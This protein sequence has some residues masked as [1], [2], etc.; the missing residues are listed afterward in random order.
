MY[1]ELAW[2]LLHRGVG[3][4][5]GLKWGL[6][7]RSWRV[8][9]RPIAEAIGTVMPRWTSASGSCASAR[10]S[11]GRM[12]RRSAAVP[13]ATAD[14]KD[15]SVALRM[16][17][18]RPHR[19]WSCWLDLHPPMRVTMKA[20]ARQLAIRADAIT[21]TS[22]GSNPPGAVGADAPPAVVAAAG[23]VAKA[24]AVPGASSR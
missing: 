16:T 11:T 12:P 10:L 18:A 14:E 1:W 5:L 9:A 17:A 22:C 20:A 2:A 13:P 21:A 23:R 19:S 15:P 24:A 3:L 8:T 7:P 6:G 4:G